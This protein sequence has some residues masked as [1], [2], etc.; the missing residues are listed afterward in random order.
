M[1]SNMYTARSLAWPLSLAWIVLIAYASLYPFSDWRNSIGTC[2]DFLWAPLP[3][4]RLFSDML[5]NAVGYVPLGFLLALAARASLFRHGGRYFW[6]LVVMVIWAVAGAAAL[7]WSM[8]WAQCWLPARR[9]SNL[10]VFLNVAGAWVGALLAAVSVR[11]GL[12]QAWTQWRMHWFAKG[13]RW[14]QVLLILWPCALLFPVE[15]PFAL[16]QVWERLTWQIVTGLQGTPLGSHWVWWEVSNSPKPAWA[17]MATIVVGLLLP[18]LLA[19]GTITQKRHRFVA[20]VLL[21][22]AGCGAT[23]VSW[24]LG[25]GHWEH[26]VS[27]AYLVR[28][29]LIA[30]WALAMLALWLPRS[31]ILGSALLTAIALLWLVNAYASA[32]YFEWLLESS[33]QRSFIHFYG[34]TRWLGWI[35]PWLTLLWLLQYVWRLLREHATSSTMR[36]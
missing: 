11:I 21:F 1:P 4:Y 10:D 31:W 28:W 13:T 36:A 15:L 16:G 29:A 18:L 9:T 8:E 23:V 5:A 3:R 27:Q 34:L 30:A 22:T 32:V 7:S 14:A 25:F 17:Q 12:Q 19:F 6:Q 26:F 35:W 24:W 20:L 2:G 33:M